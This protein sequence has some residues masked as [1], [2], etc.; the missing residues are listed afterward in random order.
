MGSTDRPLPEG[1]YD[2]LLTE[3]L[4]GPIGKLGE[5]AL[6]TSVS[7]PESAIRLADHVRRVLERT[8]SGPG[9]GDDPQRQIGL[10]N[11]LLELLKDLPARTADA[12]LDGPRL[13][14]AVLSEE[15]PGLGQ[16][17][18]PRRPEIPLSHDSLLVN[19]RT[20]PKL[21]VELQHEIASADRIDLICAFV[22]WTGLRVVRDEL[23]EARRRGVPIRVITTTYTG[24]TDARALDE[25]RAMGADVKVSYEVGATRLHAKAWL[26]ERYSGF[27]TAYIGS[28]NLTHTALHEGI[29]WNVRLTQRSSAALM[30]RFR[31]AFETY[32]ADDQFEAY[33]P[34]KFRQAIQAIKTTSSLPIA[35]LEVRPQDFQ[36]RMLERLRVERE[37]FKRH[38]NLIVAATGTGK[39]VMAAL[40]YARLAR[41]AGQWR[42]LFVAHREEILQQSLATFR[43]VM[44][45]GSFGELLVRGA[46][47]REGQHVF[48]SIQSLSKR[49]LT[50]LP[51]DYYDMVIVDEFHHAAARTYQ[52][53]LEHVRPSE[54]LGLTATP[55]RSD[56]KDVTALFGNRIAAELRL[57]EAI[58]YGHLCPFQY[59]GIS[60]DVSLAGIPFRRGRYDLDELDRVYTGDDSRVAKV[61]ESVRST[62]EDPNEMR[63]FG[64]CV[65][66][67]HAEFMARRFSEAG[68]PSAAVTGETKSEERQRILRDLRHGQVKCVFSVEVFNE[69]VDVPD[70]DTVLFLRPTESATVFLQQLGRGLRR[71]PGKAGLT[72]LDFIGQQN[73]QFRFS[74]R[75]EALSGR[76]GYQIA[77]DLEADFPFLP[78]G[79]HIHLDRVSRQVVLDNLRQAIRTRRSE[80]AAD[81]KQLGDVGLARF[82]EE[83]GRSLDEVYRGTASG[84]TSL[85]RLAGVLTDPPGRS[86]DLLARAV[87][88]LRHIDDLERVAAYAGWLRNPA[89]PD[90][91]ALSTRELRLLDMLLAGL[92][93]QQDGRARADALME[94]WSYGPLRDELAQ[95]LDFSAANAES[96]PRRSAS[97]GPDVPL[98]IHERY[99]RT[100]ALIALGDATFERQPTTR[101]GVRSLKQLRSDCFFVTVDKSGSGFSPTTR[102]RDY[103]ISPTEFHWESQSTTRLSSPTGQR[104]LGL[105]DPGWRF[106]LFVR[107][108]PNLPDGRTA[109]FLFLGAVGYV[110]HQGERPIQVTWHLTDPM[111]PDFFEAARTAV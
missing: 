26:F 39:T 97:L 104:Y 89:P 59:F 57:W 51:P 110:R 79:C 77:D 8:L 95:L 6:T 88:R 54:L 49:D 67:P 100:E 74:P 3:D 64:F 42:L 23:R 66:V 10:V 29:E 5:L 9:L 2:L 96:L 17:A 36:A 21:S 22:V 106:L 60:D 69:G 103:P 93:G 87:G 14:E 71:A 20:E 25:L 101:E 80:L 28:S 99:S 78:A 105:R 47:P 86:E 91:S 40:D 81:L 1:L 32:W 46:R 70:I 75:Y 62:I 38:R 68:I 34:A 44:R 48:A 37:R 41:A 73:R 16:R 56:L 85:R 108:S 82:L 83:T 45:D 102:Y 92:W 35:M 18:Q 94:F 84:W 11:R 27:S 53:L 4:L 7:Q 76:A 19:S 31:A 30:D 98:L 109:P 33:D 63:A 58:D 24:I 90:P 52:R 65:S 72:V 12:V 61:L 107:E 111:P 50:E 13:L 43:A 15:T 55:E